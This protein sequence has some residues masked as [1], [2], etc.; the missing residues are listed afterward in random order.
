MWFYD[1]YKNIL[2]RGEPP[3]FVFSS[4]QASTEVAS[5]LSSYVG[6]RCTV[7]SLLAW[8]HSILWYVGD[9]AI[10]W[11]S[12]ENWRLISLSAEYLSMPNS[13]NLESGVQQ[14]CNIP[15]TLFLTKGTQKITLDKPR[16]IQWT[17]FTQLEGLDYAD[18]LAVLST[19]HTHPQGNSEGLK[20]SVCTWAPSKPTWYGE[21]HHVHPPLWM[22]TLLIMM[23]DLHTWDSS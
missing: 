10:I 3:L 7:E 6:T 17:L 8:Y 4:L 1:T 2:G 21:Q 9:Y 22:P 23:K 20:R 15:P 11:S 14:G 18:D 16:S 19:N 13:L 12:P 5:C